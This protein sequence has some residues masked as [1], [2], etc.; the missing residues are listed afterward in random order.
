MGQ[1]LSTPVIDKECHQGTDSFTSFG[2]CSMQGWRMSMEDSHVAEL[3]IWETNGSPDDPIVGEGLFSDHLAMY[4]VFDGHG[5]SAVANFCRSQFAKIFREHLLNSINNYYT[6]SNIK[7]PPISSLLLKKILIESIKNTFQITDQ[8]I[9][10][11]QNL[12][13]DHSGSTCSC[14]LISKKLGT[15]ICANAGDSRSVLAL[16]GVAKTLS[17]DHKPSLMNEQSRIVAANGFV[18]TDRVNGNLALS[19]AIGDFEFKTNEN[20]STEEQIVTSFPDILIHKIDYSKDDFIIIACDGIWECLTSQDCVN[21]VY[22]GIISTETNTLND[23]A[24]KILDICCAPNTEENEIGCDNMSI[25]IVA[26]LQNGESEKEWF[27]RIKQKHFLQKIL[28][29]NNSNVKSKNGFVIEN[30]KSSEKISNGNSRF[31]IPTFESMRR[32]VYS[33]FDFD[34]VNGNNNSN[35]VTFTENE[36]NIFS[37]TTK[38]KEDKLVN[39]KKLNN[40]ISTNTSVKEK[41]EINK[42]SDDQQQ[43]ESTNSYSIINFNSLKQLLEAGVHINCQ[44]NDNGISQTSNQST[45]VNFLTS[46]SEA[47]AGETE[48]F[49]SDEVQENR[50][51]QEEGERN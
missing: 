49:E 39:E 13:N 37:I 33:T 45:I 30:L 1:I 9:L 50:E 43:T 23:I 10:S 4:S 44:N 34:V 24:S 11:D 17:F 46:L 21:M 3:N 36:S 47:V 12:Y 26:L 42:N 7:P 22:R 41:N 38:S 25:I 40:S 28:K 5:G 31:N 14:V 18:E 51:I 29:E 15:I 6:N 20:V 8:E 16:D 32:T 27:E 19:R 2:I 48:H 35:S